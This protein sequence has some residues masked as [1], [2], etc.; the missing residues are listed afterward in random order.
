MYNAEYDSIASTPMLVPPSISSPSTVVLATTES[1][2]AA[3]MTSSSTT[4]SPG[5][6]VGLAASNMTRPVVSRTRNS[7]AVP[8][9]NIFPVDII[10]E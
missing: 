10:S 9:D 3:S 4:A 8:S 5:T 7:S 1:P 6:A 2:F